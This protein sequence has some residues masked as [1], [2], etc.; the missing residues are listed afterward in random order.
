MQKKISIIFKIFVL[1]QNN[2]KLNLMIIFII[3][4]DFLQIYCIYIQFA[5]KHYDKIFLGLQRPLK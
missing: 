5:I 1:N 2:S 4:I 3:A